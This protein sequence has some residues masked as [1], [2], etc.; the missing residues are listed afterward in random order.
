MRREAVSCCGIS[1]RELHNMHIRRWSATTSYPHRD[2]RFMSMKKLCSVTIAAWHLLAVN[3]WVIQ[4]D[5][6]QQL[7][8]QLVM[9]QATSA[10][11]FPLTFKNTPPGKAI[12]PGTELRILPVGDSITYGFLSNLDGGDGNG[13]RL[14]L[15]ENASNDSVVF[16]GTITSSVGN[17]T[18]GYFAAWNGKTIQ[19]IENNVGASLDQRPNIILLHAGTNDMNPN[20]SISTE[21][22]DPVA[23]SRRL[24]SLIDKMLDSCPDAVI[25]V[26][27]I[28]GTCH[29]N[30]A[31]Q[32]EV[33]RS[34]VPGVVMSR[35]QTGKHV[36][37]VD[38]STFALS[39][40]RDCIHPTNE[41][42]QLVGDY[43]YD[44][45][46]QIPQDW[47]TKPVGD[48]PKRQ[49]SLAIQLGT[50]MTLLGLLSSLFV[51]MHT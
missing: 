36:L 7:T 29:A 10:L 21:G 18:D 32:T 9:S 19:Y 5:A 13:Y 31:P 43:W 50:N 15:R 40:L 48:D 51:L 35:F 11:P 44:F 27:M 3:A 23:A 34:L 37:P 17:M 12:K 8:S 16:A 24:G 41:G 30:Q 2:G 28:V 4:T 1:K 42:Y 45:V 25:L 47:I 22:N 49:D 6:S 26:A 14:R 33:F 20:R 38:F 39:N 46:T